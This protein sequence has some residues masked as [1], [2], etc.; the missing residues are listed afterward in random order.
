MGGNGKWPQLPQKR[1][2]WLKKKSPV[3]LGSPK[4]RQKTKLEWWQRKLGSLAKRRQ[5]GIVWPKRGKG[6]QCPMTNPCWSTWTRRVRI[7][8]TAASTTTR[9]H[10]D[11]TRYLDARKI[12]CWINESLK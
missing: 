9:A 11:R 4:R 12:M 10:L 1:I 2:G 8:R 3:R 6:F 5:R 7:G